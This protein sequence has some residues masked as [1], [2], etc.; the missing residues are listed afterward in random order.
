MARCPDEPCVYGLGVRLG[1]AE[2]RVELRF[3][4]HGGLVDE[5]HPASLLVGVLLPSHGS[6]CIH[7]ELA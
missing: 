1:S 2:S 3:R 7:C 4:V 5:D 6:V